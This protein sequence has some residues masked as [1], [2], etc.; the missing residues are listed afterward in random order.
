L[1]LFPIVRK[2]T[3]LRVRELA[4]DMGLAVDELMNELMGPPS[5][6]V[7]STCTVCGVRVKAG[8]IERHVALLHPKTVG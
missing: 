2:E 1:A 3:A 5:K 4:R 6:G 7:W 8:N